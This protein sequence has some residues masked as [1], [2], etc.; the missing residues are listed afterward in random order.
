MTAA[1][2]SAAAVVAAPAVAF[3]VGLPGPAPSSVADCPGGIN[4]NIMSEGVPVTGD[5]PLAPGAG[6]VIGA[7]SQ[8]LLTQCSGIPGC[9]SANLYGPG[10]V[11]VP[12]VSTKVQQSQ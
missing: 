4:M 12:N 7:P 2:A 11:Q 1:C 8:G 6:P 9:L 5:C 10:N 3:V